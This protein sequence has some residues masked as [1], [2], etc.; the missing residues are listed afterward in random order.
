[1]KYRGLSVIVWIVMV[2][3]TSLVPANLTIIAQ[4]QASAGKN[5]N[6]RIVK[7]GKD[8]IKIAS[9]QIVVAGKSVKSLT[10][11]DGSKWQKDKDGVLQG[12][13]KL[14]KNAK[15][16][17]GGKAVQQLTIGKTDLQYNEECSCWEPLPP[18]PPPPLLNPKATSKA[19]IK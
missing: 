6:P 7:Y 18:P 19:I 4:S 17:I 16:R 15:I 10:F 8:K 11:A 5:S 12:E 2:M 14:E 3:I 13:I 1:M 9:Q